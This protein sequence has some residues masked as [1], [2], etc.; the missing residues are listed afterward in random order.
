MWYPQLRWQRW[1]KDI[2]GLRTQK[3]SNTSVNR[4]VK[5]LEDI[6][7]V[8]WELRA[9]RCVLLNLKW[10]QSTHACFSGP[11]QVTLQRR[12]RAVF[13]Q[14]Y[15]FTKQT[16][17][18]NRGQGTRRCAQRWW[19]LWMEFSWVK[20][21]LDMKEWETWKGARI[22]GPSGVKELWS[23]YWRI[24]GCDGVAS[25]REVQEGRHVYV[26]MADSCWCMTESDTIL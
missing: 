1:G 11:W 6:E 23:E 26:P 9:H 19:L 20:R 15:I 10:D 22:A 3:M 24:E 18:N 8:Q 7:R 25:G 5:G 14:H 21:S 4:W 2:G 16:R 12:H 13:R 17:Q